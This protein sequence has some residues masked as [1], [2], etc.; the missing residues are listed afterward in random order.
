MPPKRPSKLRAPSGQTGTQGMGKWPWPCS[1]CWV[2]ANSLF[3]FRR[4]LSRH[5]GDLCPQAAKMIR[6]HLRPKAVGGSEETLASPQLQEAS[7][8]R[9]A[10]GQAPHVSAGERRGGGVVVQEPAGLDR[11]SPSAPSCG[12]LEGPSELLRLDEVMMGACSGMV[13]CKK[14]QRSLRNSKRAVLGPG[15]PPQGPQPLHS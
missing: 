4:R 15:E 3:W 14:R 10:T 8:G 1:A 9:P 13:T 5:H 12:C 7:R 6:E 11:M 2:S